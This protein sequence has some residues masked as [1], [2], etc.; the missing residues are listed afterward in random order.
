MPKP[1]A[2]L[3]QS[4]GKHSDD[5]GPDLEAS[6]WSE[7]EDDDAGRECLL[8]KALAMV[9]MLLVLAFIGYVLKTQQLLYAATD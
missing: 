8:S 2:R 9:L 4:D 7:E 5:E 3:L 6:D 1:R